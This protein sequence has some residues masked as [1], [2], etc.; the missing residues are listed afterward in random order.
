MKK[1]DFLLASINN[2]EFTPTDMKQVL[3]L[4]LDNT[5]FL[6]KDQYKQSDFIRKQNIFKD[7]EGNFSET[8]FNQIYN[9][10]ANQF[11]EFSSE[12]I[13]D[14]YEYSMWDVTRPV[15]GRVKKER[16]NIQTVPNPEHISIGVEG[17]NKVSLS[18]QSRKELAQNS[19]IFD[20]STGKFLDYSVNDISLFSN[21]IRYVQSLF[22]DPLVYATYDKDTEEIDPLTGQKTKHYKG[23]WKVNDDGEYYVERATCD[24]QDLLTLSQDFAILGKEQ[25]D[26][27]DESVHK[28]EVV[29]G[30]K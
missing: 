1:N 4:T 15:K 18:D 7:D 25:L 3:G 13:V 20:S 21:P 26:N 23:E 5:Q 12:D 8:K 29:L 22:A 27:M 17:I 24:G 6:S 30:E 28:I 10:A 19:K 11:R 2:L 9:Q 16:M 14:N